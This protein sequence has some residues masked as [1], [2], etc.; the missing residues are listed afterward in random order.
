MATYDRDFKIEKAVRREEWE[1]KYGTMVTYAITVE[2]EEGWL[3]LNQK[4]TTPSPQEGG[5]LF[6]HIEELVDNLGNSVR[7]F[8]KGQRGGGVQNQSSSDLV[9]RLTRIEQKL[10]TLLLG[11]AG[12]LNTKPVADSEEPLPEPRGGE[13]GQ[14]DLLADIPF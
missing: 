1:S 6:G 13:E 11:E 2:G 12:N 3:K 5:T 4:I 10:D 7:K 14:Q 9:E 8:N